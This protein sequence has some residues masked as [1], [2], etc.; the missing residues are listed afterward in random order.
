MQTDTGK[1]A[2]TCVPAY[3][4]LHPCLLTLH[5]T[6]CYL[7]YSTK[8]PEILT[9]LGSSSQELGDPCCPQAGA[10][11]SLQSGC[12]YRKLRLLEAL[13]SHP[14]PA[15][16]MVQ[17]KESPGTSVP[18]PGVSEALL[19]FLQESCSPSLVLCCSLP[20]KVLLKTYK[21]FSAQLPNQ[22]PS[23]HISSPLNIHKAGAAA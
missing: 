11:R 14:C 18:A 7:S 17:P 21:G 1:V 2:V 15:E 5:S 13:H 3:L 22:C 12:L 19:P 10:V 4:S 16:H 6:G 8:M 9:Q 20:H 23:Q